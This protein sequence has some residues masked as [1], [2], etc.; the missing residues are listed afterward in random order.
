[1]SA[2]E[3]DYD[4]FRMLRR[5]ASKGKLCNFNDAIAEQLMHGGYAVV[6]GEELFLTA[7]GS[8]AVQ[9]IA[10]ESPRH[11]A[12]RIEAARPIQSPPAQG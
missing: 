9:V 7:K 6:H 5:L 8:E 4:A 3:G 2:F 1:M 12:R 11:S 10:W